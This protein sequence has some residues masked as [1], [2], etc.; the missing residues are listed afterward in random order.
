MLAAAYLLPDTWRPAL[1]LTNARRVA[2][3]P[4]V[5]HEDLTRCAVVAFSAGDIDLAEQLAERAARGDPDAIPVLAT[6]RLRRGD[7]AG[8]G[9]ILDEVD[10][11]AGLG[12]FWHR[13]VIEA[14]GRGWFREALA[15]RR[16]MRRSSLPAPNL[17]EFVV[18]GL[19]PALFGMVVLVAAV[20]ALVVPFAPAAAGSLALSVGLAGTGVAVDL[21]DGRFG[22]AAIGGACIAVA[23]TAAIIRWTG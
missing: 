18:R 1:A 5:D 17:M 3:A 20:L 14:L 15:A 9:Q 10:H 19:P 12:P 16:A 22:S 7:R 6:I 13:L 8:V 2:T 23:L 4:T 21:G 11:A